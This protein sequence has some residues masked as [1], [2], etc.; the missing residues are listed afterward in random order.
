MAHQD[1]RRCAEGL[2]GARPAVRRQWIENE[3]S[4]IRIIDNIEMQI[5]RIGKR[6]PIDT[7]TGQVES[8]A[9]LPGTVVLH[10]SPAHSL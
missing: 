5:I 6:F 8:R 2:S 4:T 7:V 3:W 9:V 1:A 10:A